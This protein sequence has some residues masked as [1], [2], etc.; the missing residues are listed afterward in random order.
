MINVKYPDKNNTI[1]LTRY[2]SD[3][4]I[5]AALGKTIYK[6]IFRSYEIS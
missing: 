3:I 1:K 6:T 4:S 2:I 5:R